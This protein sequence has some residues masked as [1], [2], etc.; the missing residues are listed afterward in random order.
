MQWQKPPKEE[1]GKERTIKLLQENIQT[2]LEN[3][4]I[5]LEIP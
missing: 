4:K 5:R 3:I 2:M 1:D